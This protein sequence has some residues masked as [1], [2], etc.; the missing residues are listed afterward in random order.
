MFKQE[1]DPK[2][3]DFSN[4]GRLTYLRLMMISYHSS[5]LSKTFQQLLHFETA[6]SLCPVLCLVC[7]CSVCE[8]VEGGGRGGSR[9]SLR[10][11]E[12][13]G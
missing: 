3:V 11:T 5:N 8:R 10:I 1:Q 2:I 7:V 13:Q 4:K 9:L 6:A 12:Q